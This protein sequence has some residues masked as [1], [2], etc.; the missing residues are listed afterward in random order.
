MSSIKVAMF[1]G[2]NRGASLNQKL[3]SAVEALAP[4]S[5][6]FERI[7]IAD[8]P[9]CDADQESS[10]PP[11]VE[12]LKAA[13]ARNQA[14]FFVT[15]EFNRS[16]PAVI[17]NAIDIGSRPMADNSWRD[18]PVGMTGTSP[19][20]IGTAVGQQHLRQ[21][22]SVLGAHVL[23]G[24]AYIAFNPP[25]LIDSDGQVENEG[26]RDFIAAY[27]ARFAEFAGLITS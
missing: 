2:S 21:I 10:P 22:L 17:K 26:T 11:E 4:T 8:L 23:P 12:R 9:F 20:P 27:V 25:T 16:I 18:M 15:P 13:L 19:G 6:I 24:E 5:L 7:E 1:I 14:A 3:A